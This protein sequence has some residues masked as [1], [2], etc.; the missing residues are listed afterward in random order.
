MTKYWDDLI[1]SNR[2]WAGPYFRSLSKLKGDL[3]LKQ[4]NK[5]NIY[6]AIDFYDLY[7]HCF[8]DLEMITG[9]NISLRENYIK[10]QISRFALIYLFKNIYNHPL[11]I[12]PP[13][14]NEL[15]SFYKIYDSKI[16]RALKTDDFTGIQKYIEKIFSDY[17]DINILTTRDLIEK[18]ERDAPDLAFLFSP[19]FMAGLKGLRGLFANNMISPIIQ[20][21]NLNSDAFYALIRTVSIKENIELED[22]VYKWTLFIKDRTPD[23]FRR[24]KRNKSRDAKAI[25]YLNEINKA[26]SE[27]DILLLVS[28]DPSLNKR[29]FQ[30]DSIIAKRIFGEVYPLIRTTHPFYIALIELCNIIGLE[31]IKSLRTINVDNSTLGKMHANISQDLQTLS[32]YLNF[33]ETSAHVGLS[34]RYSDL[35]EVLVRASTGLRNLIDRRDRTSLLILIDKFYMEKDLFNW[36]EDLRSE[37]IK[38]FEDLKS[39]IKT[40]DFSNILFDRILEFEVEKIAFIR[41]LNTIDTFDNLPSDIKDSSNYGQYFQLFLGENLDLSIESLVKL[42]SK[43][44]IDFPQNAQVFNLK[45]KNVWAIFNMKEENDLI[46][47]IERDTKKG[48]NLF[49]IYPKHIY[50]LL[51]IILKRFV[52]K[53][54]T[55]DILE[56]DQSIKITREKI[57]PLIDYTTIDFKFRSEIES[58]Y[59]EINSLLGRS[60]IPKITDSLNT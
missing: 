47:I 43:A 8:P 3:D 54:L 40:K 25:Q 60:L 31:K 37:I 55:K 14:L 34:G 33:T 59:D 32:N 58:L 13:H 24:T 52:N 18:L 30:R 50:L 1:I 36:N 53:E 39:E 20:D 26:L 7:E 28:S 10:R 38:Y 29:K 16:E 19:C 12:L 27:K 4:K 45:E 23:E 46:F 5:S 48:Y 42:F 21:P 11:I 17:S 41:W 51:S 56:E 9:E 6:V 15:T 49:V 35:L 57:I 44:G 22:L 2:I